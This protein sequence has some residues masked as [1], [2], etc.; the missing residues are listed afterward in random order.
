MVELPYSCCDERR[1][2]EPRC[3]HST[4]SFNT[5]LEYSARGSFCL[6]S[7]GLGQRQD[8]QRSRAA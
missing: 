6:G 1:S 7:S 3:D 4:I 2:M 5:D 8:S